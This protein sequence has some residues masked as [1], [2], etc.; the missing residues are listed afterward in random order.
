M[1]KN[2]SK[3]SKEVSPNSKTIKDKS[4]KLSETNCDE[5]EP[6]ISDDIGFNKL[7]ILTEEDISNLDNR[8]EKEDYKDNEKQNE[9]KKEK[10]KEKEKE[11][12]DFENKISIDLSDINHKKL[13]NY[14]NDDLIDAIDKCL[15]EPI[16]NQ[17]ASSELSHNEI[18]TNYSQSNDAD[19]FN[20]YSKLNNNNCNY[21]SQN[22]QNLNINFAH[23]TISFFPKANKKGE[24]VDINNNKK[25]MNVNEKKDGKNKHIKKLV[26]YFGGSSPLDAPVYIPH[27]FKSLKFNQKPNSIG[28]SESNSNIDKNEEKEKKEEKSKKPFEIREGDWTCE[29][30]YNLNFAFRTKCNRCGLIKDFISIKNSLTMN[31]H[32][33]FQ[34]YQNLMQTNMHLGNNLNQ[35]NYQFFNNKMYLMEPFSPNTTN[36]S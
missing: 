35:N 13:H 36:Y 4:Q 14:L 3:K 20:N 24:E 15:D 2:I 9:I 25:I 26:D 23:N 21:Y 7:F 18:D 16:D 22:P 1:N 17:N 8:N 5:K 29:F 19:I 27:K 33:N 31:T 11:N 28:E 6:S 12:Q 30:C 10:E 32:D 34:N